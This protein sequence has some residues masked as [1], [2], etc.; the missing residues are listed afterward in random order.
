MNLEPVS[1]CRKRD[2]LLSWLPAQLRN[3]GDCDDSKGSAGGTVALGRAGTLGIVRI[4]Y[5][6][7]ATNA[8]FFA[9]VLQGACVAFGMCATSVA[10]VGFSRTIANSD[11]EHFVREFT[12]ICGQRNGPFPVKDEGVSTAF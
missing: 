10:I 4:E 6:L 12:S 2:G 3:V 9:S 7:C 8:N 1:R 5:A 11:R